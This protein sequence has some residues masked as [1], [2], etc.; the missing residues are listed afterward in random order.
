MSIRLFSSKMQSSTKT[1]FDQ[2]T[3]KNHLKGQ[4]TSLRN[5]TFYVE[6]SY[7][8]SKGCD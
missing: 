2:I 1:R 7:N 6:K 8:E 3:V 5:G 4:A